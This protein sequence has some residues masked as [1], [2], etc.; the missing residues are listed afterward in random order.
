MSGEISVK[1]IQDRIEIVM[2]F[3]MAARLSSVIIVSILPIQ[4]K[5]ITI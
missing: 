1:L 4:I 2:A 3:L 5:M